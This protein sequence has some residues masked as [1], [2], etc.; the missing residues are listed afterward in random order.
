MEVHSFGHRRNPPLIFLHG[1]GVGH[2][3]WLRQIERFQHSHFV[4]APDIPGLTRSAVCGGP[5]IRDIAS[6]L[7]AELNLQAPDPISLCGISAGASVALALAARLGSRVGRLILSAPQARA[8]RLVLNLQITVCALIPEATLIGAASRDVRYD[9][10]IAAAA[11]EDCGTLGKRGLLA[12]MRALRVMDLRPE[13]P[14]ITAPTWVFCGERDRANLPAARTI[15]TA[16][17]DARLCIVNDA[18]T[19]GMSRLRSASTTLSG[20][21]WRHRRSINPGAP[22]IRRSSRLK[23]PHTHSGILYFLKYFF[24]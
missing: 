19:C 14:S 22:S 11:A 12:A 23:L 17:G 10:E 6:R 7:V 3:L 9:H 1:I 16:L 5:D 18:G 8:P 15:A 2:R 24:C 20:M 13:L 21:R 4:M